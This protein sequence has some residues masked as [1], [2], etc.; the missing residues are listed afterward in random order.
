[1]SINAEWITRCPKI[2]QVLRYYGAFQSEFSVYL[3]TIFLAIAE[4]Y[5]NV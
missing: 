3:S 1:M 5:V 2:L 4:K